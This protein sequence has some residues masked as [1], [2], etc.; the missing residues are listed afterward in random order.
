MIGFLGE[1]GKSPSW[2]THHL[3]T[4]RAQAASRKPQELKAETAVAHGQRGGRVAPEKR[5]LPR[6]T[7]GCRGSHAWE[8]KAGP[9]SRQGSQCR[10][11]VF[12]SRLRVGLA[13]R[14]TQAGLRV[15]HGNRHGPSAGHAGL[16]HGGHFC[17]VAGTAA[18]TRITGHRQLHEQQVQQRK[19]HC[20]EAITAIPGH[21]RVDWWARGGL[22]ICWL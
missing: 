11:L 2:M 6:G 4:V 1:L 21:G 9:R 20:C 8:R 15:V 3:S 14:G 12:V 19:E 18:S 17:R 16:R 22:M 10:N 5:R 13:A 7:R